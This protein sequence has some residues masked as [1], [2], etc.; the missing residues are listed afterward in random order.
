MKT[1]YTIKPL[2]FESVPVSDFNLHLGV[3]EIYSCEFGNDLFIILKQ[4]ATWVLAVYGSGARSK[5]NHNTRE[6]AEN[7]CRTKVKKLLEP[8]LDEQKG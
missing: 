5:E 8:Y 6:E 2:V 3:T 7:S 4:G 1:L